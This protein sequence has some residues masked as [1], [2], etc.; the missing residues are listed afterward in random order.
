LKDC[1][2]FRCCFVWWLLLPERGRHYKKEQAATG[3][4]PLHI[5]MVTMEI[6][7][8]TQHPGVIMLQASNKQ[9]PEHGFIPQRVKN[10]CNVPKTALSDSQSVSRH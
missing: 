6:I 3:A 1:A 2:A 7:K 4:T 9:Y 10:N 8:N 5:A